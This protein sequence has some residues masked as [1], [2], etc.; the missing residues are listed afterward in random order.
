MNVRSLLHS[1]VLLLPLFFCSCATTTYIPY[2]GGAKTVGKGASLHK[3]NGIDFWTDGLPPRPY[4]L[5][6]VI[7]DSRSGLRKGDL[8]QD[9]AK[10]A[11]KMGADAILEYHDYALQMGG[12]TAAA[13]AA[14]GN[15]IWVG[16]LMAATG[17]GMLIAGPAIIALGAA[18]GGVS[19]WWA[20][21]YLPAEPKTTTA[22]PKT[23][24]AAAS[25]QTAVP[26]TAS[27]QR[28]PGP[29]TTTGAAP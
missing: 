11:K 27:S 5:V 9:L 29:P 12:A 16:S 17:P 20:A 1:G 19:R 6:G 28:P 25:K 10:V 4:K 23:P 2:K 15:M 26:A 3:V 22:R 18:Q 24:S 7:H 13:G 21:K 8:P 14:A